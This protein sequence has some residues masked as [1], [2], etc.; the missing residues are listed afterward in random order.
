[1]HTPYLY[2]MCAQDLG[3]RKPQE[4]TLLLR[5]VPFP[6]EAMLTTNIEAYP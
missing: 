1:M 6:Q 2:V 5:L 4:G 3:N